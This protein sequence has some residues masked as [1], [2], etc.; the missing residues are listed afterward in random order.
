MTRTVIIL[1]IQAGCG[2]CHE[3]RPTFNRVA[4]RYK[5]QI[6][7]YVLDCNDPKHSGLADRC[8]VGSTPT[9]CVLRAPYGIL[10]AEGAIPEPEL[11]R[12][13]NTAVAYR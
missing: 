4:S 8:G 6:P 5:G 1:W 9:T 7:I 3:F 13:F 12:L 2:A 11:A 10:K